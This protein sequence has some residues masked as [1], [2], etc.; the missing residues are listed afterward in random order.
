M[1]EVQQF[2][3]WPVALGLLVLVGLGLALYLRRQILAARQGRIQP[4]EGGEAIPL[5]AAFSGLKGLPWI[6][7]ASSDIAPTLVLHDD[8]LVCR[9]LK[10]RRIPYVLVARVDFRE[11]LATTNIVLDFFDSLVSFTG[12][13]ANRALA[14]AAIRRLAEKG[15]RLSPRARRLL[16]PNR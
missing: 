11:T 5:V 10:T 7:F 14:H 16:E 13:T 15:C 12:N 9:V 6:S 2:T 1:G 8:H 3:F 4:R